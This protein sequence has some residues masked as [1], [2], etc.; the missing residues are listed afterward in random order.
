MHEVAVCIGQI[1]FERLVC[2]FY[3]IGKSVVRWT[4]NQKTNLF[5]ILFH[6]FNTPMLIGGIP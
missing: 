6:G 5:A 3:L 2:L 1:G 4:W